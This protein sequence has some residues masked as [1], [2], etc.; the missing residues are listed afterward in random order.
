M[1]EKPHPEAIYSRKIFENL[2]S[3]LELHG[4]LQIVM[5]SDSMSPV[6]PT[7]ANAT[8]EPF[9]L[10]SLRPMDLLV[11]WIPEE[12]I[13]VCHAFLA[14]GVFPG[15]NGKKTITTQGIQ[16]SHSDYP[17]RESNILGRVTSH[18][19]T[20]FKFWIHNRLARVK[21]QIFG[22]FVQKCDQKRGRF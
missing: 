18:Q 10:K 16:N 13:I 1:S 4:Q 6:L 7:G 5:M 21:K 12:E 15:A 14:E 2:R 3:E 8:I 17:V 9:R 20:H 11:F 19:T 22:S